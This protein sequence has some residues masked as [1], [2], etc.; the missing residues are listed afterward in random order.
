MPSSRFSSLLAAATIAFLSLGNAGAA[1]SKESREV[2]MLA[3]FTALQKLGLKNDGVLRAYLSRVSAA[4]RE[5][6][7]RDFARELAQAS[8]LVVLFGQPERA[9]SPK[10]LGKARSALRDLKR[11]LAKN[12]FAV[13]PR[14]GQTLPDYLGIGA[15]F[16]SRAD[17]AL[18]NL[19]AHKN[20]SNSLRA[21][22][23]MLWITDQGNNR[24]TV[25][26]SLGGAGT[27]VITPSS[28]GSSSGTLIIGGTIQAQADWNTSVSMSLL[29]TS[30]LGAFNSI[31]DTGALAIG[32]ID[33][34]SG[35]VIK[36]GAGT[37][38]LT[39]ANSYTGTVAVT[40]GNL[41]ILDTVVLP[42]FS[43]GLLLSGGGT[44][45][46][47][48]PGYWAI[49]PPSVEI[50]TAFGQGTP[51][52]LKS[53]SLI[54]GVEYPAGTRLVQFNGSSALLPEGAILLTTPATISAAP[55]PTP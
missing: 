9:Q 53:S 4:Y 27:L 31:S 7:Y 17:T 19:K 1:V 43:N 8:S 12:N 45:N 10:N 51:I 26:S 41:T 46:L 40:G 38:Q 6:G 42:N 48:M 50:P 16:L 15:A 22:K 28:S 54:G 37:L 5:A 23:G 47:H 55:T 34:T 18:K 25:V 3:N 11:S 32:G 35:G 33:Q 36:V 24:Y 2:Q 29:A 13:L 30:G 52:L 14:A 21:N 20:V 39:G 49:F 44:L